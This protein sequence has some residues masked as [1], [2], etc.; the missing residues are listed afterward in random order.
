MIVNPI[1]V[2]AQGQI[3]RG[4]LGGL[5]HPLSKILLKASWEASRNFSAGIIVFY[6]WAMKDKKS[7]GNS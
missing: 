6:E 2:Y 7:K 4:L 3:C 1:E 5:K